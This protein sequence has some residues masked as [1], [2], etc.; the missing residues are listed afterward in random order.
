MFNDNIIKLPFDVSKAVKEL[1]AESFYL[2]NT[3][4]YV[5]EHPSDRTIREVTGFGLSR[6]QKYK[7]DLTSKGYLLV[8]QTGKSDYKYTVGDLNA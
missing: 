6:H 5:V 4:Y 8:E 2:L 7:R 1:D 3:I